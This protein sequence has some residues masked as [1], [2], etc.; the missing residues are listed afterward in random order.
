MQ[1]HFIFF[2]TKQQNQG[3]LVD[4]PTTEFL[5]DSANDGSI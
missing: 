5:V 4:F 1:F 2:E 3:S